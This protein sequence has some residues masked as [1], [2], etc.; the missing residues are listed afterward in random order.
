MTA[1]PYPRRLLSMAL[2]TFAFAG[3]MMK[4]ARAIPLSKRGVAF[5]TFSFPCLTRRPHGLDLQPASYLRRCLA[6]RASS[7][8]E[9]V[10][11]T[12]GPV[13]ITLLSGFL[14]T[15]KTTTLKH[16]LENSE[17]LKIGVIVNDVAQVNIDAKLVTG[18]CNESW[19]REL[20]VVW[21]EN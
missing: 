9:T 17:N 6:R 19:T 10:T 5:H 4:G 21:T 1:L 12:K 18:E 11:T 2:L 7:N 13:P 20:S 16:L 15:G 3:V 14:G 8:F